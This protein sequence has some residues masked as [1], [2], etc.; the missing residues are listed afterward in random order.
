MDN[1]LKLLREE[2]NALD[3]SILA[4]LSKRAACSLNIAKYKHDCGIERL[5]SV[6]EKEIVNNLQRM[7]KGSLSEKDIEEV[8]K[9][10]ITV[11]RNLT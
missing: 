2:I 6:R 1:K 4:I 9:K 8:F 11:C 5:D 3:A 10:I 7:N